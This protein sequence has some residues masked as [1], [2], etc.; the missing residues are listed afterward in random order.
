RPFKQAHY[1]I[2]NYYIRTHGASARIVEEAKKMVMRAISANGRPQGTLLSTQVNGQL[3]SVRTNATQIAGFAIVGLLLAITG[4]YGVLSY[5]VQQ[6]TQEI[7]IRGV[8]G[9]GRGRILGMVLSQAMRL[10]LVGVVLGLVAAVLS[11]RLMTGLLYGTP[12]NDPVVYASV[13]LIALGVAMLASYFPARR[14]SLVDPAIA[15]RGM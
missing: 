15:L 6:R 12:T 1:W 8:L 14:A 11:M 5:V 3:G 4:L 2:A 13:A 7:G 10:A 9:A